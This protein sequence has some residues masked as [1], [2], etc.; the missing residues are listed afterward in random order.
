MCPISGCSTTLHVFMDFVHIHNRTH[1][2]RVHLK[3]RRTPVLGDEVY[4]NAD[5]NTRYRRTDA[6]RRPLLH[7]YEV[8]FQ[9]PTEDY[10]TPVVARAPIPNDMA[11][12]INKITETKYAYRRGIV[13]GVPVVD[14]ETGLLNCNIDIFDSTARGVPARR[15]RHASIDSIRIETNP[16]EWQ[17][18]VG[19][20]S[21]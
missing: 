21:D 5:W 18:E 3:D 14:G 8:A 10:N 15:P 13:D 9:H 17:S 11:S 4:G 6:V 7:A 1:Q 19:S 20:A 2:I 12:L 16:F